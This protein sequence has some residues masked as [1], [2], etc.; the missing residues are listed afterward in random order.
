MKW[1]HIWKYFAERM[2]C[3]EFVVK[4][5]ISSENKVWLIPHFIFLCKKKKISI[6]FYNGYK[7]T[8][9]DSNK[10]RKRYYGYYGRIYANKHTNINT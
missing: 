1:E 5:L 9:T 3:C 4:K 8:N 7:K 6:K 2:V 10:E